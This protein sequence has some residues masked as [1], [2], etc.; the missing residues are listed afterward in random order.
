MDFSF[1]EQITGTIP[2]SWAHFSAG[3]IYLIDT[4]IDGCIPDGVP[5]VLDLDS[6]GPSSY[7]STTNTSDALVLSQL[8]SLLLDAGASSNNLDTWDSA[9]QETGVPSWDQLL[10]LCVQS[11]RAVKKRSGIWH[12][13]C[14]LRNMYGTCLLV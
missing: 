11:K 1:N 13:A 2:A 5:V 3:V 4:T 9:P 7:C 6:S 14:A 8:Q 12:M 10:F